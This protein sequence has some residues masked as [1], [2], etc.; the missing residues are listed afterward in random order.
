[1][2]YSATH[3]AAAFTS[4]DCTSAPF[5]RGQNLYI[6]SVFVSYKGH[7]LD[8]KTPHLLSQEAVNREGTN[9]LR[10]FG[11]VD[12]SKV[13]SNVGWEQEFFLVDR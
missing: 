4:W 7:A 10:L 2:F 6:P 8:E 9:L 11:D 1:M 3:T 12:T 13:V 5:V